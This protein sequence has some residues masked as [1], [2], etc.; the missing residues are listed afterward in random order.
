MTNTEIFSVFPCHK[1][2]INLSK[3]MK[4][5]PKKISETREVRTLLQF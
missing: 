3:L 5:L 1:R 2:I 4:M